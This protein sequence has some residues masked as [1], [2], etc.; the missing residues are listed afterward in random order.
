MY[1]QMAVLDP[2]HHDT[3]EAKKIRDLI[4]KGMLNNEEID[5]LTD[6]VQWEK[7]EY[8][9]KKTGGEIGKAVDEKVWKVWFRNDDG[10]TPM[11]QQIDE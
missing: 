11:A 10:K 2:L 5:A 3:L 7:H 9:G 8:F 1:K 6:A 4:Q